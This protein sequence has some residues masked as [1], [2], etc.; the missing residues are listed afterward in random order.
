M[1]LNK[2]DELLQKYVNSS[3]EETL[4]RSK[5]ALSDAL[6]VI[7]Q[8]TDEDN[9]VMFVVNFL[10]VSIAVDGT[11]TANEQRLIK[12]LIGTDD[13]MPALKQIDGKIIDQLDALIDEL[14]AAEKAVLIALAASVAAVDG[15]IAGN[16]YAYLHKLLA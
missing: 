10:C 14:D 12:D 16:E 1:G 15:T 7:K 2:F 9:A 5:L 4:V 11:F 8:Y 13:L 6:D 3:Y